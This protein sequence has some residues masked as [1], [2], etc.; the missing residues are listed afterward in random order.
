MR[1]GTHSRGEFDL[2]RGGVFPKHSPENGTWDDLK[3]KVRCN[4]RSLSQSFISFSNSNPSKKG[5]RPKKETKVPKGEKPI[6]AH[7]AFSYCFK[8]L[9]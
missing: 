2:A 5:E 6:Q 9:D 1:I 4:W 7:K 3:G 8:V